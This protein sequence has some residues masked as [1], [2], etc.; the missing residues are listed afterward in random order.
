MNN[1]PRWPELRALQPG[2]IPLGPLTAGEIF[3]AAW[4]TLRRYAG[5]LLGVSFVV[6]AAGQLAASAIALPMLRELPPLPAKPTAQQLNEQL[7]AM[8]PITGVLAVVSGFALLL[9][10]GFAAAVVGKAVLG[11]PITFRD[12]MAELK[13]RALTLLVL[14]MGISALATL[15]L[16]LI[17][18]GIWIFVLLSLALPAAVLEHADIGSAA[19]RSRAL[20]RHNWW[21]TC[22]MQAAVVLASY[23]LL[24]VTDWIM[25]SIFGPP[26]ALLSPHLLVSILVTTATVAYAGIV[27]TLI[28]V[29]RRFATDD[30]ALEL[31]RAAGLKP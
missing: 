10:T 23:G 24:A 1:E 17:V 30:L 11:R 5:L 18:P 19:N 13:P 20:V 7:M 8:A 26:D 31:A 15:G 2:V 22:G 28:Y 3:T 9:I 25:Q 12:A 6:V 4:T 27:I 16:L 29:D 14:S 21:R